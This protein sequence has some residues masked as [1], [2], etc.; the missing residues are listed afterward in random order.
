MSGSILHVCRG[1]PGRL[2]G[3]CHCGQQGPDEHE[4]PEADH[5]LQ[6]EPPRGDQCHAGRAGHEEAQGAPDYQGG[7]AQPAER[8]PG[9]AC[10]LDVTP[11]DAPRPQQRER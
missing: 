10:E 11:A 9:Q 4:R 3:T 8:D 7:P 5:A 1:G 6:G 2:P